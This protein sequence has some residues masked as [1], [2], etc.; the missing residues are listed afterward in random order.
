MPTVSHE[1][2]ACIQNRFLYEIGYNTRH[3][4]KIQTATMFS[5]Y[6]DEGEV[7]ER[8]HSEVR[9]ENTLPLQRLHAKREE[10]VLLEGEVVHTHLHRPLQDHDELVGR[11]AGR[12]QD[13]PRA[14]HRSS[15]LRRPRRRQGELR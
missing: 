7:S 2:Q 11:L 8:V 1:N 3:H 13:L 15:A 14:V 6:L 12:V 5:V 4:S 10:R 9:R